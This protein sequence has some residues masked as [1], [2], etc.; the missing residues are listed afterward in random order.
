MVNGAHFS[1]R[2]FAICTALLA[3]L[4]LGAVSEQGNKLVKPEEINQVEPVYTVTF[5]ENHF[6]VSCIDTTTLYRYKPGIRI[7]RLSDTICRIKAWRPL[8][9]GP[10]GMSLKFR[11]ERRLVLKSIVDEDSLVL[12]PGQILHVNQK[13][14]PYTP[15]NSQLHISAGFGAVLVVGTV[16][17]ISFLLGR[18]D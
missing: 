13:F 5:R 9:L 12:D 8:N 2:N 11:D 16:A 6:D 18:P 14:E 3:G 17:C 4:A 1:I 10:H 15:D 7:R